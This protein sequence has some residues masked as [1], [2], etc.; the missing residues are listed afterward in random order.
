MAYHVFCKRRLIA[1]WAEGFQVEG[2]QL[3]GCTSELF[4]DN[5]IF[6][7]VFHSCSDPCCQKTLFVVFRRH[8]L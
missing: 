3:F 1:P 6:I 8:L 2:S 4:P 7:I 5:L